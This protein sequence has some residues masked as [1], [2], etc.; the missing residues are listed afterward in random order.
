MIKNTNHLTLRLLNSW[1]IKIGWYRMKLI[2]KKENQ[3]RVL[4]F[5]IL[6]KCWKELAKD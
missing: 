2:K 1:S 4:K 3:V 5:L 6:M